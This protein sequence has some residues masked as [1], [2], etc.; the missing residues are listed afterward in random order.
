MHTK[1]YPVTRPMAIG[2]PTSFYDEMKITD[3]HIFPEGWLQNLKECHGIR[4]L[5]LL[6]VMQLRYRSSNK[7]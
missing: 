3:K 2:K 4:Q 5:P 6:T 7:E 1:G